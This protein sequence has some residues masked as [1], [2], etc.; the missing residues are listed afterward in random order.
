MFIFELNNNSC[1][2]F[3]RKLKNYDLTLKFFYDELPDECEVSK[4]VFN[5]ERV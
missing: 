1:I 5:E 4:D 2:I 3:H